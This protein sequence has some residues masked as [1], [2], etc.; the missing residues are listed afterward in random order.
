MTR[1]FAVPAMMMI[2]PPIQQNQLRN[3]H[4]DP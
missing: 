4:V 1:Q 3:L 2:T